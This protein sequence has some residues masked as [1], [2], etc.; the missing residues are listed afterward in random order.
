MSLVGSAS[1][2]LATRAVLFALALATNVILARSLGPEGRGVYAVAV[3]VPSIVTLLTN[4][5]IGPA[6][7]YHVSRASLDK[8][9]LV[10]ASMAAAAVLG[11]A[12]YGL[13]ALTAAATGGRS[14]VGVEDRYLLISATSIPFAL[15]SAFMLGVLQG[16]GRFVD[17]N[18][19]L[20]CQ[21]LS[22]TAFLAILLAAPG[23][24]VTSSIA[25]WTASTILSG[26][27]SI[28]LVGR[29]AR[30]S[31]GVDIPTLR[32]MLRYGSL[33]YL[34]NLTSF[35]NYRF[36]LLLV[37]AFA[38][39]TQVGL[40]A[41]GAG[42][43]EVI[44]FLP[45]SAAIALAPRAAAA[46]EELSSTIASRVTRSVLVLAVLSALLMAALAPVAILVFFGR[47]FAQ[48]ADAVWLL[49]P[50][51]VTFSAWK[52]MSSYL[53]GRNLLKQDLVASAG[54]M[55]VTLGLD[56]VL[57]PRYGF[58]GA[59]VASSVAY[60][61][62]MVVDLFWV[63]RRSKLSLRTWLIATPAD[64]QLLASRVRSRIKRSGGVRG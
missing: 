13:I 30:I 58:R 3:L 43:A 7:V 4:L 31:I 57:I 32:A 47:A 46:P 6:N 52:T 21:Y 48:S 63:R 39:A 5:G 33:T 38:G 42:L 15:V 27:L 51:I 44:W 41:V 1:L 17:F 37:N 62:A 64:G 18:A 25:A 36:D 8:G 53:L 11:V 12:A 61:I 19:V 2:T 56:L 14:L 45:N 49:L 34:G 23:D 29:R 50:G 54:A 40:Y 9:Q 20:L 22:L 60:T 16:E 24:R 35:V 55:V 26:L 10:G 59:A 28:A